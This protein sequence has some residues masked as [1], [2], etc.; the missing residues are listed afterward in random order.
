MKYAIELSNQAR[1]LYQLILATAVA[2]GNSKDGLPKSVTFSLNEMS[3]FLGMNRNRA[4]KSLDHLAK[5]EPPRKVKDTIA[6]L[7]HQLQDAGICRFA[8]D[9]HNLIRLSSIETPSSHANESD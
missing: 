2:N 1:R 7:G 6:R 8:L 3:E 5:A 9:D 4:M